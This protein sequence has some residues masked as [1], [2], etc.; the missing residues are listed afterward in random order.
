[1]EDMEPRFP[2]KPRLEGL[3]EK[4]GKRWESDGTYRFD[5]SKSREEI[6]AVDT[7]PPTVSGELHI[8]HVSSYTHTDCV[9]RF[10]RMRGKETFYPMGWDDNGLPTERRVENYFGVR[11]DPTLA[12]DDSFEPKGPPKK[13]ERPTMISR[14]NF[15]KLCNRL[16]KEDEKAF[17]DLWRYLGLSVD[18][19]QTYATI[20]ER[21]RRASQRG[22]LRLLEKGVAYQAD[23]PAL[24]DIDYKTHVA[25]AELEDREVP[26][27]FHRIAFEGPDGEE[28]LIETTRPELI[29]ACV[30]LVAH[31]DDERYQ[32]LFEREVTTPLFGAKVPVK[33]HPLADPEKGTGIAMICTFGDLTDVTWWRELR[34]PVR[35]V[36]ERDGRLKKVEWGSEGFSSADP[37]EA[38]R[39]YRELEGLTVHSAQKKIADLLGE[40]G[41]LKGDPKPTKHAVK[42]YENGRRPLEI[43][44]SRQWFIKVM[45]IKEDLIARGREIGWHPDFMKVRFEDWVNGLTGDWNVSR[46]RFYGVPF[47]VWYPVGD[48][49][50]PDRTKPLLAPEDRLPVDPSTDVP[51]GYEEG[52][53]GKPGGF[54]GDPDILDTWATSSLTPHIAGGWEDDKELFEKVFPMDLRPQGHDIIR[55][56]LFDSVV[57]AHYENDTVPWKHAAISGFI[58]D[59]DRKKMSKSKGNVITP[60]GLLERYGSD[61]V[62]Y[63]AAKARPG[64][65]LVFEES[66]MKIGRRLA[67][68]ILHASKFALSRVEQTGKVTEEIDK[69]ML[70]RLAD[71]VGEAT[72]AFEDY[73]YSKAL[74][75]IEDHFWGFCDN[76]LELVKAR[77]YASG[78]EGAASAGAALEAA[79]SVYLR[80]FA[81]FMP[82]VCEEVWSWWQDGSIHLSEWPDEGELRTLAGASKPEVLDV[83]AEVL[84][85]IRKAKTS[86][87]TSLK[88]EVKVAKVSDTSERIAALRLAEADVVSAGNVTDLQLSEDG[89]F[90]VVV[91]LAD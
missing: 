49:G 57:R 38:N 16:T 21:S 64:H 83:A 68:K 77:S 46:Q 14:P 22:F 34:L 69:A 27:A 61:G 82:Y 7:P 15:I 54:V 39:A 58:T 25:Q 31:P 24:W 42:F 71:V 81:P 12:Y 23:A 89:T 20:D 40:S 1:M 8:G 73:E 50:N 26:G 11:C 62:R 48:D 65:D 84:A 6:Y 43:M 56:W 60:M 53:R 59:P 18:W 51:D 44:S 30:A 17:E 63:W 3:E 2:D 41:H 36:L 52:H 87:K 70:S 32:G 66:Q 45:D 28:V 37:K 67:T 13:G 47:P 55:T 5:R 72:S 78:T 35:T 33:A 74:D 29:P 90:E 80:L 9:V 10:Q 88:T 75:V 4:W 76:F 85:E 86:A 79:I 91:Q 19:T